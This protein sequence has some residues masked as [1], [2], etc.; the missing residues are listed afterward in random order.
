[1][2]PLQL[3]LLLAAVAAANA[4]PSVAGGPPPPTPTPWPEQY[5]AVLLTNY[6]ESGGRL[7]LVD[8]YYDWPRGRTLNILRAQLSGEPVFDILWANGST[9]AFDHSASPSCTAALLPVGLLPPDWVDGAAY[10]GR[11]VVDGFDCHIWS[12][13]FFT[14][15]YEEV[16]TGRPVFWVF[17]G[18]STLA[19]SFSLALLADANTVDFEWLASPLQGITTASSVSC[20]T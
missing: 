2:P 1:M 20:V 10:V 11:D 5:H 9:Y 15:Y 13:R 12:H 17:A 3:L 16:A 6:T 7:E 4:P 8:V 14:R 18:S 19:L